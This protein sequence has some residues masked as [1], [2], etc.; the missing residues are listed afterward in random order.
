[1]RALSTLFAAIVT[2]S[3]IFFFNASAVAQTPPDQAVPIVNPNIDANGVNLPSGASVNNSPVI[4]IGNPGSGGLSYSQVF[5][6]NAWRHS[7]VGGIDQNPLNNEITVFIGGSSE[8][9]TVSGSTYTPKYASQSTLTKTFGTYTY[10]LG[11]GTVAVFLASYVATTRTYGASLALLHTVTRPNGFTLTYHYRQGAYLIQVGFNRYEPEYVLSDP[12]YRLQSVTTNT[13]Y[14]L[15][16]NYALNTMND[17][18]DFSSWYRVTQ[19]RLI[20]NAVD[21]CAPTAISCTGLTQTWPNLIIGET[22]YSTYSERTF[23][24][25]LSR[26]TKYVRDQYGRLTAVYGPGDISPQVSIGYGAYGVS[27]VW[28]AG[29]GGG[30]YAYA[31]AAGIRTTTFTDT[32]SRVSIT[33]SEIATGRVVASQNGYGNRTTYTYDTGGRLTRVTAPEGNYT[34]Y[35]YDSRSNVTLVRQVAK[36]GSGLADIVTSTAYPASCTNVRTCN[37]PSSV[38]DAAGNVTDFTY[39]ATH[40][41]MLTATSPAPSGSGS[42]PQTRITYT[43][44]YAWYK[45]T[46]ASIIQAASPVY[47]PTQSSTCSSGTA[48]AGCIGTTNEQLTI[49]T[50]GA[51]GV[52]NNLLPVTATA[53]AGNTTLVTTTTMTYDHVSNLLTVDGPLAGTADTTRYRY[54]NGRQ[55]IGQVGPDPDGAGALL[56]PAQR[57]TYNSDGLPTKVEFGTVTSQ[58]DAAWSAFSLIDRQEVVYNAGGR[59]TQARLITGAS[60]VQAM[61]QYSYDNAGRIDCVAQ[62]MNAANWASPPSSACTLA[63][64]GSYGPDRITRNTYDAVGRVATT[65]SGYAT[66][67]AIVEATRAYSN[68]GQLVSLTDG[69][70]NRTQYL[71][72]G[73]DRLASIEYPHP[74]VP[75][76]NTGSDDEIYTYDVYGRLAN[77]RVRSD[78]QF[79]YTYDNLGRVTQVNA[80]G[81]TIDTD[82]TYDLLGR[83]L[84]VATSSQSISNSY[85]AL[86][87]LTQQTGGDG[88]VSYQY[89]AAGHRSR[90][91]WPDG[92]YVKYDHNTAGA[93]TAVRENGASSGY[94]VLATYS[95]DNQGRRTSITRGN[96]VTTNYTFDSASR[97]ASLTQNLTGTSDDLTVTYA[98]NPAGQ[99]T[100]R[101]ASNDAFAWTGHVNLDLLYG[102]NGLNQITSVTGQSA[103]TYDG[104]GNMTG[105]GVRT[106]GY[107]YLNRLTSVSGG[108]T[109]SYDPLGRLVQLT[110]TAPDVRFQYD[111]VDMI[112]EYNS[113][114]VLQRRYVHG[115]GTDE[116]LV[117]YAGSGTSMRLWLIADERGSIVARTN[118]FGDAA[119]TNTYDEY[120]MPGASNSGRYGYTGQVWLEETGLYHYKNRAYNPRLGRFMQT[121]PIGQA[122]GMNIYA[123]VGGDPVNLVD[124]MGL[125]VCDGIGGCFTVT[126]GRWSWGSFM[127]SLWVRSGRGD[128]GSFPRENNGNSRGARDSDDQTNCYQTKFEFSLGAQI[129]LQGNYEGLALG[130]LFDAG[131]YRADLASSTASYTQGASASFGIS[132]VDFLD[133]GTRTTSRSVSAPMPT[134]AVD[135]LLRAGV[136]AMEQRM[137]TGPSALA[138]RGPLDGAPWVTSNSVAPNVSFAAALGFGVSVSLTYDCGASE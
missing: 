6:G 114:H 109:L 102:T 113:S 1:M 19:A 32:T 13:G 36:S 40:G 124:P 133:L 60:S 3:L 28:I 67:G 74:S 52:A 50:Y 128:R 29:G 25:T 84:S 105:D 64:T 44:L 61:I 103:P 136:P 119:N 131:T 55:L 81:T 101:T 123:Y 77:R 45:R 87:R 43:A 26:A 125:D 68:N 59:A 135:F 97:L 41:G 37:Q 4:T 35:T 90:I 118:Q 30:T 65:T 110:G 93:V 79:F 53:Q 38:T 127:G 56:Y 18:G 69:E 16:L 117:E 106:F 100:S 76:T 75:G 126:G 104:R 99:I 14:Q 120:G 70:G 78:Q 95:Y 137:Y 15:H 129:A 24:D 46:S 107:D 89:D 132:G 73:F 23:Y 116:P 98:Y 86:G 138:P 91:T 130:G 85:D 27:S 92:F 47:L 10:T 71:R 66:A 22:I 88:A 121:D 12:Y 21:Y 5:V 8:L 83:V 34:N 51:T 115:P 112:A 48:T 72:D 20:N 54:D 62:R 108:V 17:V 31:D 49:V 96:G 111:G 80:P 134:D 33:E 82:Y 58:S 122:G 42:R 9:F 39:D 7:V 63:T 2:A 57:T 94:G 11:D